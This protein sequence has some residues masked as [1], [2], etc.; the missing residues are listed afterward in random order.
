MAVE[1]TNAATLTVVRI[2]RHGRH[3][4]HAARDDGIEISVLVVAC[5]I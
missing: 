3:R 1:G 5:G 4:P 2:E